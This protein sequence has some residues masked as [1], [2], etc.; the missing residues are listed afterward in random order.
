MRKKKTKKPH[1]APTLTTVT[2]STA[3]TAT[4]TTTTTT[5]TAVEKKEESIGNRCQ[6]RKPVGSNLKTGESKEVEMAGSN[7]CM[8]FD[9]MADQRSVQ[10]RSS[11][12]TTSLPLQGDDSKRKSV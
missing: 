8:K 4:E 12:G 3:T 6:E 5:E 11:N 9:T 10:E 7:I 1:Q 2:T